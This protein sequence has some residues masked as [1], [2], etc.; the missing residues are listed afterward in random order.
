MLTYQ[1][2]SFRQSIETWTE[3]RAMIDRSMVK[4]RSYGALL[5]VGATMGLFG[6]QSGEARAGEARKLDDAV[7]QLFES[8]SFSPKRI[9]NKPFDLGDKDLLLLRNV[10]EIVRS[11]LEE[12]Y[13]KRLGLDRRPNLRLRFVATP[14]NK[15]RTVR[16]V[17]ADPGD[18]RI[19]RSLVSVLS[20][21]RDS[22]DPTEIRRLPIRM[23]FRLVVVEVKMNKID[24]EK[25]EKALRVTLAGEKG[26]LAKLKLGP[27]Q[28]S[29]A[30]DG[31]QMELRSRWLR[32]ERD[33]DSGDRFYWRYFVRLLVKGDKNLRLEA[34]VEVG[35]QAKGEKQ[36]IR[37][38]K[39]DSKEVGPDQFFEVLFKRIDGPPGTKLSY[40]GD[41]KVLSAR[42]VA[43]KEG[44]EN[45]IKGSDWPVYL[46]AYHS[47]IGDT[48]R[49]ITRACR[50]RLVKETGWSTF[51]RAPFENAEFPAHRS[52]AS[53]REDNQPK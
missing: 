39:L 35:R 10:W 22:F 14:A 19:R 36:P 42:E 15:P 1:N 41:G 33:R 53:S 20:L 11:E 29:R 47:R 31:K 50:D 26:E 25:L 52:P 21:P 16:V 4:W 48:A 9:P 2:S 46:L 17:F 24:L 27:L 38:I 51:S 32:A 34:G 30:K 40:A 12:L 43:V 44:K 49:L 6:I 8:R 28:G 45:H 23:T 13:R 5:L 18:E 3:D 7:R 37:V